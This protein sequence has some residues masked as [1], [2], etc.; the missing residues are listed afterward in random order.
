M[1]TYVVE[2][3]LCGVIY[4]S[5]FKKIY[6]SLEAVLTSGLRNLRGCNVGISDGMDL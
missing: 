1:K 6:A 3:V 4:I 5:S 2:L